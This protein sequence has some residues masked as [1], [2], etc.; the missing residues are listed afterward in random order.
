[1][2]NP[3]KRTRKVVE[4][5]DVDG[6]AAGVIPPARSDLSVVTPSMALGIGAVYRAV[7]IITTS[8]SQMPLGVYRAGIKIDTPTLIQQP[9]IQDTQR[10]FIYETV[11]SL[12]THGNAYWRLFGDPVKVLRVLDPDAVGITEEQGNRRYWIGADEIPADQIKHLRLMRKPGYLKGY[13][14]IQFGQSELQAALRLRSFADGW[15]AMSGVPVGMLTT[16]QSLNPAQAQ[17]FA[18][19]WNKF[20]QTN[21]T[22]VL[23]QG[24]KYEYLNLNPEQAQ[25]LGV[26]QA[27]VVAI[28]RLFGVPPTLLATSPEGSSMTYTNQQEVWLQFLTTTLVDYMN[29]I[30]D[31]LSSLL[32]RGQVVQFEED[33]L[34]RMNTSLQTEVDVLMVTNGLR[35]VNEIRA[36]DGL[37]PLPG[38][39]VANPNIG[40]EPA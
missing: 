23:S 38:G 1:M 6:P 3:F 24:M 12:A 40:S 26:Q 28:A 9:D 22:A 18:D 37:E 33:A 35:T 14:P 16:D 39:N 27:Q 7:S 19:A 17:A 36:R 2:E 15:F 32:P 25:Y 11:Y 20:I 13:G 10:G 5:R 4:T 21:G 8:V 30:E 31:A 34:L 29:E